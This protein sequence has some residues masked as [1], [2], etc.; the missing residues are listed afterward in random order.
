M[1][2][3][4]FESGKFASEF[5]PSPTEKNWAGCYIEKFGTVCT[6]ETIRR[7]R[8]AGNPHGTTI[9]SDIIADCHFLLQRI[10]MTTSLQY[11]SKANSS[12]RKESRGGRVDSPTRREERQAVIEKQRTKGNKG[13]ACQNKGNKGPTRRPRDPCVFPA[14][15]SR[16]SPKEARTRKNGSFLLT[17]THIPNHH[18]SRHSLLHSF[19]THYQWVRTFPNL[20]AHRLDHSTHYPNKF[21]TVQSSYNEA[22]FIKGLR[23]IIPGIDSVQ[24]NSW[25]RIKVPCGS[26]GFAKKIFSIILGQNKNNYSWN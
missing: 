6:G 18:R 3:F 20:S 11:V 4:H 25:L 24:T 7:V 5:P 19:T 21:Q 17:H 14:K 8:K 12:P 9:E 16:P 15:S 23:I 2:I 13:S 22:N 26:E 10:G 1:E